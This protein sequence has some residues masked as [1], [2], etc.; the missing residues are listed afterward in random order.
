MQKQTNVLGVLRCSS[1]PLLTA[2]IEPRT[3]VLLVQIGHLICSGPSL[4]LQLVWEFWGGAG[5]I[6]YND[7]MQSCDPPFSAVT[8]CIIESFVYDLPESG[9][10]LMTGKELLLVGA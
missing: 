8:T 10:V 7:V 6:I 3:T 9:F 2:T 5:C 1:E 4:N